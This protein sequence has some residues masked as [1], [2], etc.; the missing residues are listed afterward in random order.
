MQ[1]I[2]HAKKKQPG[3]I[4][5]FFLGD[6]A[7]Q[8]VTSQKR[9]RTK[10]ERSSRN[11]RLENAVLTSEIMLLDKVNECKVQ[12]ARQFPVDRREI[13]RD[14]LQADMYGTD[15]NKMTINI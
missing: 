3:A 11:S 12:N 5:C 2:C 6:L 13:H 4:I 8:R 14:E 7:Q 1:D 9:A 10:S 15:I